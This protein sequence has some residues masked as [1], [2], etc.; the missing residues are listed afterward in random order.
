VFEQQGFISYSLSEFSKLSEDY[1]AEMPV[2]LGLAQ[3]IATFHLKCTNKNGKIIVFRT[4]QCD[5]TL[6]W[7]IFRIN[8]AKNGI[9]FM[10]CNIH[11]FLSEDQF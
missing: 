7:T 8:L 4:T 6:L 10:I 9:K 2:E 5:L 11:T 3:N 1:S